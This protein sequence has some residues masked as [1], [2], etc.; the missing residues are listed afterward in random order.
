MLKEKNYPSPIGLVIGTQS[1]IDFLDEFLP[2][3]KKIGR[4]A[5]DI[6]S[7]ETK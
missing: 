4:V 1:L 5:T 7:S 2:K 3:H 6:A